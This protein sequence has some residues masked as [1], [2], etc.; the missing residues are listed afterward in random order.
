MT[1]VSIKLQQSSDDYDNLVS[2]TSQQLQELQDR[3]DDS[4]HQN[5]QI[6]NSLKV[7]SEAV[8]TL[9]H[10]LVKSIDE[11]TSLTNSINYKQK[12]IE[13]LTTKLRFL[14]LEV[15]FLLVNVSV[16]L[17]Q[18]LVH[19]EDLNREKNDR[20]QIH[21]TLTDK[22]EKAEVE[23]KELE[24]QKTGLETQVTMIIFYRQVC[25]I[26]NFRNGSMHA[27]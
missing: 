22:L 14:E 1:D 19:R 26:V 23:M 21:S 15:R 17:L 16:M 10:Q 18:N 4:N 2:K 3:L 6:Q 20:E 24:D 7:K 11:R 12:T 5:W 9:K 25:Y 8:Q 13:D 27:H